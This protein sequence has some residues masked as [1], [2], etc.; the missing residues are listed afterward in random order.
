MGQEDIIFLIIEG[1]KYEKSKTK[2]D[3]GIYRHTLGFFVFFLCFG[4][5]FLRAMSR[6][7]HLVEN[8]SLIIR[9]QLPIRFQLT[10]RSLAT[11]HPVAMLT[12][13]NLLPAIKDSLI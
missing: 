3:I 2:M 13:I 1:D 9:R 12:G 10:Q 5:S 8:R 7:L 6:M 11:F 4:F